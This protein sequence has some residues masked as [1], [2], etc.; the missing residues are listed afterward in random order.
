[1]TP[2]AAYA[3]FEGL[4]WRPDFDGSAKDDAVE[5]PRGNTHWGV[6]RS[7]YDRSVAQGAPVSD[8]NFDTA[9]QSDFGIVLRR[10][11]WDACWCNQ[12]VKGGA[13]GAAGVALILANMAMAAGAPEAVLL[14]QRVVNTHQDGHMGPI[15]VKATLAMLQAGKDVI[16]LLTNADE[17]F[18]ATLKTAPLYLK[19]WDRRAEVFEAA[20]RLMT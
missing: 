4:A 18:F 3:A 2:D 14:L 1:V 7:T 16:G 20:A 11:C 10:E 15:T 12:L 5:E 17:A 8:P 9:P 6:V 19:G 13:A